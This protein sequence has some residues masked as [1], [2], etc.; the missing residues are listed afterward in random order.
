MEVSEG[1]TQRIH[2]TSGR[3]ESPSL[4]YRTQREELLRANPDQWELR[5]PLERL[6]DVVAQARIAHYRPEQLPSDR[7]DILCLCCGNLYRPD[8]PLDAVNIF[9][10]FTCIYTRNQANAAEIEIPLR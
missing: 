7:G 8:D 4:E 2:V 3:I 5:T 10:C 9:I 1:Q 6:F